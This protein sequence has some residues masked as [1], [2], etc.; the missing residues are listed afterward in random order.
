[1]GSNGLLE[2]KHREALKLKQ[3]PTIFSERLQ[4][5]ITSGSSRKLA[6]LYCER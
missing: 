3:T 2:S 6:G 5:S 4:Q 1:M